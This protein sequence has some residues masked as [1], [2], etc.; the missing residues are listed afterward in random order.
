MREKLA[1]IASRKTKSIHFN[2]SII[3]SSQTVTSAVQFQIS[4]TRRNARYTLDNMGIALASLERHQ[5][6][7]A[8]A[9]VDHQYERQFDLE[10]RLVGYP[11]GNLSAGG[12]LR[13]LSY[14]A[15]GRIVASTHTGKATP[16]KLDQRYHYD[17][18]DRLIGFTS[19]T[20]SQRFEYDANGNR[21]K[22]TIGSN[23]YINTIDPRSNRLTGT[24]GP[25]RAKRNTYDATGN[26]V[27]DGTIRYVYGNNGRLSSA[28]GVGGVTIQYRYNG[29]GQRVIKS[30]AAGASTYFVYNEAGQMVGEYNSA[31]TPI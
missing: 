9:V 23:S 15:A 4:L 26:L 28:T 22:A 30:D 8:R 11:L 1:S 3:A 20:A 2:I 16:D 5:L 10:N 7:R 24:S 19:A 17:G 14:D 12:A 25:L 13:T 27:S 21:T 6:G 29:L 31:G 18:H